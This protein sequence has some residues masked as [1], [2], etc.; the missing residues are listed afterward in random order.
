MLNVLNALLETPELSIEELRRTTPEDLEAKL[1]KL[2]SLR[3]ALLNGD[4]FLIRPGEKLL[5]RQLIWCAEG[6][7]EYGLYRGI[8][9][10]SRQ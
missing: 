6:D 1:I 3:L 9:F 2:M 5:V 8:I 7:G 4:V 10:Q